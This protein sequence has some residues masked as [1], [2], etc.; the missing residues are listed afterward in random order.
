VTFACLGANEGLN[1]TT[2]VVNFTYR[3]ADVV[4]VD[5][6]TIQLHRWNATGGTWEHVPATLSVDRNVVSATITNFGFL[7]LLADGTS[8]VTA[9]AQI[10]DLDAVT[11]T[12][13]WTVDLAWT[14]VGD[15][16][17]AGQATAYVLKYSTTEVVETNWDTCTRHDLG[18]VPATSGT[19]RSCSIQ[20]PDPGVHYF[21][22]IKAQD[23]A[24]NCGPLSTVAHA[25]SHAYDADGDSMSDQWEHT[26]GLNPT[27]ALDAVE[28]ADGDGLSNLEE[29]GLGTNPTSWD[30]DGDGMGDKWETDHGLDPLSTGDRTGDADGDGLLNYQEHEHFTDP[31]NPDTD[32]DGM[33][34][35]WELDNGLNPLTTAGNN[36]AAADA[37]G[38]SV[39][40]VSEYASDTVPTNSSSFLGI[41]G[42]QKS[43][44]NIVL[45]WHGGVLATQWVERSQSLTSTGGTWVTVLTNLPPTSVSTNWT[46]ETDNGTPVFYRIKAGR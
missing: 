30:S 11:G 20:M 38:D 15:D 25:Q 13:G 35:K 10:A 46:D 23:E 32:A 33:P 27:N 12:N 17:I 21:F 19:P 4:G 43:G 24:G 42:I 3:E 41:N 7:A 44:G 29:A 2:G 26:Y 34:D 14:D 6:T 37:D 31:N 36:G 40:N 45:H 28:D 22:G 8:D 9:P 16:G 1:G 39:P 18:M 5:E